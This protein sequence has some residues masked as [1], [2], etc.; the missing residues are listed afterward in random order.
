MEI[1][2]EGCCVIAGHQYLMKKGEEGFVN[3]E[4]ERTSVSIKDLKEIG[5]REINY[6]IRK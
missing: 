4:G 1:F 5:K 2:L 3:R 6:F